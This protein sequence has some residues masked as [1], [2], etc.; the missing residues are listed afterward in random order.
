LFANTNDFER[1]AD[2]A[3]HSNM[4]TPQISTLREEDTPPPPAPPPARPH[5][6]TL[7]F[8]V[9]P[10]VPDPTTT[11][12]GGSSASGKGT[13]PAP[14]DE[15]EEE[16][17][18]I[19]DDDI[20]STND[21]QSAVPSTSTTP[22]KRRASKGKA[23]RKG[24]KKSRAGEKGDTTILDPQQRDNAAIITTFDLQTPDAQV[25]RALPAPGENW[26]ASL[27]TGG[28]PS[29]ST[30]STRGRKRGAGR[31]VA[32]APRVRKTDSK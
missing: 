3:A 4:D 22:L 23:P 1:M 11:A 10:P 6:P 5:I 24:V 18:L 14:E 26:E 12:V 9:K 16:D 8:R 25:N 13:T 17:Q 15:D 7:K 30:G 32:G 2:D 20:A 31:K 27:S 19:D 21:P 29:A 28:P